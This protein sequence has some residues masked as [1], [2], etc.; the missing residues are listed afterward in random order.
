MSSVRFSEQAIAIKQ[1]VGSATVA[2]P[3]HQEVHD[4][5]VAEGFRV[6]SIVDLTGCDKLVE[7][8]LGCK[9]VRA[10]DEGGILGWEDCES[11]ITK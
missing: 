8:N 1:T 3:T 2:C 6:I 5:M 4:Y 11:G 9:V 7:T 10:T